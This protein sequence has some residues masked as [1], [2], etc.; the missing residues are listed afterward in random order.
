METIQVWFND[1]PTEQFKSY[2]VVWKHIWG[3]TCD[4]ADFLFKSYY[5][6]WKHFHII[7]IIFLSFCLNRTM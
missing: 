3:A 2:Y 5:V 1:Q 4:E 7:S 6:V